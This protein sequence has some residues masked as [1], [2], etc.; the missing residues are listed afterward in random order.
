[1]PDKEIPRVPMTYE[2]YTAYQKLCALVGTIGTLTEKLEKRLKT[3]PGGWRDARMLDAVTSSLVTRLCSTIP[4]AKLFAIRR[5]IDHTEVFIRTKPDYTAKKDDNITYVSEDALDRL[6]QR[7]MDMECYLC[8]K[9]HAESKQCPIR[10]DIE[11]VYHF[12]MKVKKD[13]TCPL[14]G[15]T[16]VREKEET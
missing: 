13:G 12:G 11:A 14:A 16:Y 8:G 6:V 5:E 1:M 15:L 9:N 3:V 10:K 4:T 2:E 7:V